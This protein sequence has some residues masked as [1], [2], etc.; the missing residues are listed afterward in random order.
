M[1]GWIDC[2]IDFPMELISPV[3]LFIL[4]RIMSFD[5]RSTG[6]IYFH[7]LISWLLKLLLG[8]PTEMYVTWVTL[9]P[10][11]ITQVKSGLD[12]TNLNVT[13]TGTSTQFV[14]GA[15]AHKVRY[16][17]RVTL[18]NLI[19]ATRYCTMESIKNRRKIKIKI[20]SKTIFIFQ[21]KQ[22]HCGFSKPLICVTVAA[23]ILS[24]CNS[25]TFINQIAVPSYSRM[26]LL[27]LLYFPTS[28]ASQEI[29]SRLYADYMFW[30]RQMSCSWFFYFLFLFQ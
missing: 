19:P 8:N 14:D 30:S 3:G 20:L 9:A 6:E 18:I 11:A 4:N 5:F 10:S 29:R 7:L 16:I 15:K 23:A 17:H 26:E 21:T 24:G 12:G 2:L 13:T 27:P 1:D 28:S 22:I 25:D